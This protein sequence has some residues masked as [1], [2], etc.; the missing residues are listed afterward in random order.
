MLS[1]VFNTSCADCAS[2]TDGIK[3]I[4]GVRSGHMSVAALHGGCVACPCR[5]ELE[6]ERKW[7]VENYVGAQELVVT[8]SD[9]R[10]SV[11]IYNCSGS[12]VQVG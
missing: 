6:Q 5:L 3:G 12:V 9:P 10:H 7:V 8:V 4:C 11:Y 2:V 1:M